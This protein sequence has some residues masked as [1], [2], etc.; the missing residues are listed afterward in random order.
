MHNVIKSI[1]D[2]NSNN[3][4]NFKNHT[5]GQWNS[6]IVWTLPDHTTVRHKVTQY[7]CEVWNVEG[8]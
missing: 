5:G 7:V 3:F 2:N 4:K 6:N 1:N 8:G